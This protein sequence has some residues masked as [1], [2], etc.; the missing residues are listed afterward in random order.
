MKRTLVFWFTGL[1]GSG[2]TAITERAREKLSKNGK[3]IK[4]YDGDAVRSRINRH[5]K[6]SPEDIREN[7]RVI[8]ELCSGDR[9]R[10]DYIFVSVISPFS[11]SRRLARKIIGDDFYLIY[12]KASLA[13]VRRRDPKGLYRKVSSGMIKNFIGVDKAIPYQVPE[14][15]DLVLD[16]EKESV[17]ESADKL[18]AFIRS[19]EKKRFP[20]YRPLKFDKNS[21]TKWGWKCLYHKNLITGDQVDISSFVLINAKYGVEMGDNVQIGPHSTILSVSTIDNKRGK[22]TIGKNS[23]IGAYSLIMPGVTIGE[24]VLIG[25]Y[26]FVN[27]D[28]PSGTIWWGIPAKRIRDAV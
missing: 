25:A 16:T 15:A 19:R 18:I 23:R 26:S 12:V 21:M 1:S 11:R 20:D 27:R 22:V 8:A 13:E 14:R 6:F 9:G 17:K 10:Y 28:I 3:R 2:K 4:I 7:N 5:L 24:D